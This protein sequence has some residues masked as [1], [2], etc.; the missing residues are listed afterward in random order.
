MGRLLVTFL[1]SLFQ[2]TAARRRLGCRS[3]NP[4]FFRYGFNTQPPEGG[5]VKS[6]CHYALIQLFQHT[7]ARRRLD[8]APYGKQVAKLVSTH[9]RPKAAGHNM[10]ADVL[11]SKVSTHSRPKAAGYLVARFRTGRYSFNT[12]PPEGGWAG[13]KAKHSVC[14]R[15]Q[16]TAA[17]RRLGSETAWNWLS[18]AFQHTAARRRLGFN[19][20]FRFIAPFCFNTQP[21]EG[22]W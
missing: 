13:R 7:A 11:D 10:T 22:G 19:V 4:C 9:S 2:H 1:P 18:W 16:H 15:F 21:P 3:C 8:A 12:Q 5:W 14:F 17:R 6:L 20:K